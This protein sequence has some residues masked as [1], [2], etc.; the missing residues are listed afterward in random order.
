MAVLVFLTLIGNDSKIGAKNFLRNQGR[1]I[2]WLH[3]FGTKLE[4]FIHMQQASR[5]ASWRLWSIVSHATK[6][7]DCMTNSDRIPS[8]AYT[9]N[10]CSAGSN[11]KKKS[12]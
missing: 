6:N 4:Y 7:V 11:C 2:L 9:Q 1:K 8:A 12:N 3:L 10:D 5:E